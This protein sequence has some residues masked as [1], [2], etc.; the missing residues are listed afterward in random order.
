LRSLSANSPATTL[1]RVVASCHGY[2]IN[3]PGVDESFDNYI[4]A[5]TEWLDLAS[6]VLSDLAY[7]GDGADGRRRELYKCVLDALAGLESR[8]VTVLAGTMAAPQPGILDWKI[9]VLSIT[10]KETDPGAI[11]RRVI[12]VDRRCTQMHKGWG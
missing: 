6:S 3:R 10:R 1:H 12:W 5:L 9:A 4:G 11:K 7:G 8:G 2:L